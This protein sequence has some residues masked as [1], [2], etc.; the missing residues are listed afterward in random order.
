VNSG[1]WRISTTLQETYAGGI[2]WPE[3]VEEVARMRDSLAPEELPRLGILG[4][5]Y[6]AAGAINLFGHSTACLA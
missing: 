3:L 1:W 4:A 2:G 5:T 6:G